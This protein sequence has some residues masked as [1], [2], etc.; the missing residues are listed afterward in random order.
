[1]FLHH[2]N[3]VE[4]CILGC[5]TAEFHKCTIVYR[6]QTAW[7]RSVISEHICMFIK[8]VHL[9]IFK[10]STW[11]FK[12]NYLENC[13]RQN[14]HYYWQHIE[15]RITPSCGIF[16]FDIDPI[17]RWRSRWCTFRLRISRKIVTDMA[18]F[19]ITNKYKVAYGLAIGI[20]TFD[21]DPF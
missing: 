19:A 5:S 7:P 15:I 4:R 10:S 17:L 6:E 8:T 13:G 2:S 9:P 16:I 18:S 11:E 3:S 14:K 21:L 12:R 20:F 1:M